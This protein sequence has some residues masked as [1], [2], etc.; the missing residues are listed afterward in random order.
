MPE[1]IKLKHCAVLI[2]ILFCGGGFSV[3]HAGPQPSAVAEAIKLAADAGALPTLTRDN[4]LSGP[5]TN[6]NGVR[7]DIDG[8]INDLPDTPKQKSA[9][10][11]ATRAI[12][13]TLTV[14]FDDESLQRVADKVSQSIRC[15]YAQYGQGRTDRAQLI[16]K[17]VLNTSN[18]SVAFDEYT[19]ATA[20]LVPVVAQAEP[21]EA[22]Q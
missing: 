13:A 6:N 8:Y 2:S 19:A 15:L 12:A 21:C 9:M 20:S 5:D 22:D 17:L 7:D 3:A 11:Q 14:D 10:R 1:I 4:S 16:E 18:R